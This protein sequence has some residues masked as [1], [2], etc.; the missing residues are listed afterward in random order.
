MGRMPLLGRT[1]CQKH[2]TPRQEA[3]AMQVA[4]RMG[5]EWAKSESVFELLALPLEATQM[6]CTS[7]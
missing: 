3:S 7:C 6:V 5:V 2:G 4:Q 1:L